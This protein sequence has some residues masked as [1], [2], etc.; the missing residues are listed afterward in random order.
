MNGQKY[1]SNR[2]STKKVPKN[3]AAALDEIIPED[4][5]ENDVDDDP[6]PP[7]DP[8]DIPL[9]DISDDEWTGESSDED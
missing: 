7:L 4:K 9:Q 3:I 5:D 2:K 6:L 8:Q 1:P